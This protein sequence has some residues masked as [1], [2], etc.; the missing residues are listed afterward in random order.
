VLAASAV[1]KPASRVRSS[2]PRTTQSSD[3]MAMSNASCGAVSRPTTRLTPVTSPAA[4]PLLQRGARMTSN[5]S[6]WINTTC[7]A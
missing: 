5:T 2:M 6:S 7:N 1:A 4:I 3:S